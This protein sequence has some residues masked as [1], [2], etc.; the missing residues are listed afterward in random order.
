MNSRFKL[1]GYIKN[2]LPYHFFRAAV[3]YLLRLYMILPI[4]KLHF[5]SVNQKTLFITFLSFYNAHLQ[6]AY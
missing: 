3:E 2:S 6:E 1:T 4:E 5:S